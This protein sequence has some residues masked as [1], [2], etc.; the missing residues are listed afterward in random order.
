MSSSCAA[1]RTP[2]LRLAS[3]RNSLRAALPA[4]LRTASTS[5]SVSGPAASHSRRTRTPLRVDAPIPPSPTAPYPRNAPPPAYIDGPW[6]V[7][8]FDHGPDAIDPGM[9]TPL[10]RHQ[11]LADGTPDYVR[12][13]LNADIYSLARETPLT[14]SPGLST[15]YGCNIL[16]KREDLQPVFSF[17]LRGAYNMMRQLSPEQKARGVVTASA[18]NHAQ[19]VAMS[20]RHLGIPATIYMPKGTPKI[21]HTNVSRLGAKVVLHGDD[22]DEAKRE[23]AR[24]ADDQGMTNVPPFDEPRVIAGQGTIAVEIGRQVDLENVR[25]VFVSVGG[26]GLLAGV[27]AYLKRVGPPG[28]KVIGVETFDA[29]AGCRSL[30]A[31]RRVTLD[32]VGLFADGTA[33]KILG[34]ETY[35]VASELVDG[36]V[37]VDNDAICAAIKD[38]FEGQY[39]IDMF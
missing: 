24:V 29:D 8:T 18:G 12:M 23:C 1:L 14:R 38:V 7:A 11:K 33:V 39:S 4:L 17:K 36:M 26:G 31:G 20:G 30:Q 6:P 15:K 3:S 35:R 21:K 28:L 22:F 5:A 10:P 2:A 9:Y 16:L 37:R 32:E 25:A 27:A 13:I 34:A 19:G